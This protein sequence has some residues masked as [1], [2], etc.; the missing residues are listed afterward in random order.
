MRIFWIL[1][2]LTAGIRAQSQKSTI[3]LIDALSGEP[4][5]FASIQFGPGQGTISNEEGIFSI[6]P[7]QLSEGTV[8]ISC[9]GYKSEILD[10]SAIQSAKENI[11]LQPA[12]IEL[13]E[14]RLGERIPTADEIIGLVRLKI[15][16]NY[17][18]QWVGH[19]IF[20]R[21]TEGMEFEN[22][23]F[24]LDKDSNLGRKAIESADAELR[25]LGREIAQ[26]NQRSYTFYNGI[27]KIRGDSARIISIGDVNK[28]LDINKDYDLDKI[29]ERA[30]KLVSK[31][32]DSNKTYTVKTGIFKIEDSMNLKAEFKDSNTADSV[33]TSNLNTNL[34]NLTRN[35][36]LNNDSRLFKFLNPDFYR[37]NFRGATYFDG[38]YVYQVDFFPD[39]RKAQ[40]SGSLFVDANSF[41]ILKATYSYAPG[42]G[43]KTVNL[44]LLLGIKY[45]E[46][47]S[48]GM[49]IFR[50]DELLHQFYPYII[51]ETSGSQIYLHRNLKFIPNGKDKGKVQFDFL[52]AGTTKKTAALWLKPTND[53]TTTVQL[54][55]KVPLVKANSMNPGMK[56][57]S[58][59]EPLEEMKRFGIPN[60]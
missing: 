43:G 52:M 16:E 17:P 45:D 8:K 49:V 25:R 59:L 35:A 31:H 4:I 24:S 23:T 44:K 5:P 1:F 32:L 22:L 6:D 48:R 2:L 39:S 34:Q 58:G 15:P 60:N 56:S 46:Y 33:L 14:V 50:K 19:E 3:K 55:K 57:A 38:N 36:S 26:S 42:K 21:E 10:L 30:K 13:N 28:L 11:K 12:A 41:A 20:L 29:Q 9:L 40:Y 18:L 53:K 37:Y 54:P 27:L 47:L 51:Q 7:T